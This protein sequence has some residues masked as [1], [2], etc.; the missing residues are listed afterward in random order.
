MKY[1]NAM[2]TIIA[3]LLAAIVGKLYVIELQNIGPRITPPTRGDLLAAQQIQD[4]DSR[5]EQTRFLKE[6]AQLVWI[7]GGSSDVSGSSIEVTNTISVEGEVT[8]DEP[9]WTPPPP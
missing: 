4:P 7:A 8:L 3:L 2:L 5:K 9:R 1:T 6:R